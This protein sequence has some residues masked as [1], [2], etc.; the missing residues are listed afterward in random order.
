MPNVNSVKVKEKFGMIYSG[1]FP[2]ASEPEGTHPVYADPIDLGA[3]VKAYLAITY[4]EGQLY[5]DDVLQL[6]AREFANAQL[7]AET[8]LNDLEVEAALFGSSM[9]DGMLTDN[10]QDA[11]NSGGYGYI[12]KLKTKTGT[13][14]R[15]VFLYKVTPRMTGDNIDT[16]AGSLV[17]AHN[18]V[19][20]AVMPDATGAWRSRQDFVTE[21]AAKS[22]LFGLA[23]AVSGGAFAVRFN[24]IGDGNAAP[25]EGTYF[26][27]SGESFEITFAEDPTK[28]YDGSTDVTASIS[29][30]KYT[31]SA[32]AADH[33]LT[34]IFA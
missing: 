12:Q 20:Y 33:Q 29:G 11:A 3:A 17:F 32:I 1:F 27:T 34:A 6:D 18:A 23:K 30:H 25:G 13:V 16:K 14:Y 26:V 9:S 4:A 21:A 19:T 5:G 24:V 28:L 22:F 15:P 8:L 2:I 7:D 31:V 10:A